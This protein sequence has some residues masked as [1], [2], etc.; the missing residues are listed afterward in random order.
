MVV[1]PVDSAVES[2]VKKNSSSES[3]TCTPI[4][5]PPQPAPTSI[6]LHPLSQPKTLWQGPIHPST[7]STKHTAVQFWQRSRLRYKLKRSAARRSRINGSFPQ[8]AFVGL[9]CRMGA[10]RPASLI[11]CSLLFS[12]RVSSSLPFAM[13]A[14]LLLLFLFSILSLFSLPLSPVSFVLCHCCLLLP[15]SSR[16]HWSLSMCPPPPGMLCNQFHAPTAPPP[17]LLAISLLHCQKT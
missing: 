11:F 12:S 9:C 6:L 10:C 13:P 16:L 14:L 1:V 17:P 4:K 2:A 5:H 3:P 15:L 8:F 7:Y